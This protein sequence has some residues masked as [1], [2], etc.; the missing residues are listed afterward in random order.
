MLNFITGFKIF[1]WPD[2]YDNDARGSS[3]F[4]V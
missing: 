1:V 2:D 4:K 3:E